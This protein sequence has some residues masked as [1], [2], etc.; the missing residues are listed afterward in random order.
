M[1]AEHDLAVEF[2][3]P[4][5]GG[6][7][8]TLRVASG[9]ADFCLTGVTYYLFAIGR[10]APGSTRGSLPQCTS[11]AHWRPSWRPG[12]TLPSPQT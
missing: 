9:G 1:F 6:R 10:R 8:A 12:L 4:P 5:P 7:A 11:E 2:L 3:D